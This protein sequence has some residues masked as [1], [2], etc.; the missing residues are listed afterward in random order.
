MPFLTAS[1]YLIF[2]SLLLIMLLD[3]FKEF[4]GLLSNNKTRFCIDFKRNVL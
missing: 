1:F 3:R 4:F 2:I